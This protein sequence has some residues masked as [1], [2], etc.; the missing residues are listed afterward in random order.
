MNFHK[1]SSLTFSL[2]FSLTVFYL[3]CCVSGQRQFSVEKKDKTIEVKVGGKAFTTYHIK[4]GA[5]PVMWPLYG[6]DQVEM[7]RTYPIKD[8]KKSEKQDHVHHRSFWFTHGDVNGISYWHENN[9]HGNIVHRK[10]EKVEGGSSATIVSIN[11]WVDPKGTKVCEDL[12]KFEFHTSDDARWI[13]CEVTVAAI[14]KPVIFGDTKEGSFGVRVA[15]TMKVESGGKIINEK[16]QTDAKAWGKPASWVDYHGK[17]EGKVYGVAILN[18]PTSYGFPSHWHVRNYGLF[19]ANPFGLK[20]FYGKK[21]GKDG[22][23]KLGP[24]ESFTLKYRVLLHRGDEKEG[25]VAEHF[26]KYSAKK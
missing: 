23:L 1:C 21:S 17:I 4:S 24:K 10:F 3:T 6:P 22:T 14:D 8:A 18:H 19:T 13:D 12:R 2:A 11:D 20:A 26:K 7:T 16:G 15:G 5:K 25:K 9:N